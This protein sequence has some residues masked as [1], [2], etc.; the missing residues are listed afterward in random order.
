MQFTILALFF[1]L[2][3]ADPC[4]YRH[5]RTASWHRRPGTRKLRS[6]K[7]HNLRGQISCKANLWN[8]LKRLWFNYNAFCISSSRKHRQEDSADLQWDCLTARATSSPEDLEA[9]TP[10]LKTRSQNLSFSLLASMA[11]HKI[12]FMACVWQNTSWV[13]FLLALD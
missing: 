8:N 7:G 10:A 13:E 9:Q 12:L 3:R 5:W 1:S 6:L 11:Y 2:G 4:T